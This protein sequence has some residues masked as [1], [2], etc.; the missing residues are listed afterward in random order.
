[1]GRLQETWPVRS[2]ALGVRSLL[3]EDVAVLRELA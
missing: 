2:I 3:S 1:M